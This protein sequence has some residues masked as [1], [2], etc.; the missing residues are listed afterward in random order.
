MAAGTKAM[1]QLYDKGSQAFS[2]L[3]HTLLGEFAPV[4]VQV[5]ERIGVVLDAFKAFV[6]SRGLDLASSL[7]KER[8]INLR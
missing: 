2:S 4:L 7:R 1:M 8:E 5:Q 3:A 6:S